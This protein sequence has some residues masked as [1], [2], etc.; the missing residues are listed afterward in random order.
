[1]IFIDHIVIIQLIDREIP[2]Y[3]DPI[4]ITSID[5]FYTWLKRMGGVER[6]GD[7]PPSSKKK[8]GSRPPKP[9]IPAPL[10]MYNSK[11]KLYLCPL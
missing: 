11:K 7:P 3:R 1:M 4:N 8:G 9:P 2:L 5:F 10:I 6:L